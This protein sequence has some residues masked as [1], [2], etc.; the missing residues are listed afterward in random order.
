MLW[1]YIPASHPVS[2]CQ[3]NRGGIDDAEWIALCG[4]RRANALRLW[5]SPEVGTVLDVK[6][7]QVKL[8]LAID[9][10]QPKEK[11]HWFPFAPPTGNV[12]YCIPQVGTNAR[13]SCRLLR[14]TS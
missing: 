5:Q 3:L 4:E 8:H 10:E 11:A 7:E 14:S 1:Q 6:G 9:K 13:W 12:M 2:V